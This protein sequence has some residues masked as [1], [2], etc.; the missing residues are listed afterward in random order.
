MMFQFHTNYFNA[1]TMTLNYR[2]TITIILQHFYLLWLLRSWQNDSYYMLTITIS[3][4]IKI[5]IMAN[6]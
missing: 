5:G 2:K 6:T 3:D 4:G 1:T